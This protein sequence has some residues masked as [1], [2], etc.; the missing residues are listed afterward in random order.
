MFADRTTPHRLDPN[1]PMNRPRTPMHLHNDTLTLSAT[2]L[3]RHLGCE[4]LTWLNR[5]AAEGTL[6]RPTWTDPVLEA[7]IERGKRHEAEY[8]EHLKARGKTVINLDGSRDASRVADLMRQGV[9]VIAQ[10]WLSSHGFNGY[11][12]FLKKVPAPSDLGTWSYE[13][14]DTKLATETKAGTILQLSLYSELVGEIQGRT[15]E[16][17]HVVRPGEDPDPFRVEEYGAYY[18]LVRRWLLDA[19][20]TNGDGL[21]P[22]PCAECAVCD[23]QGSCRARWR[24]D[25]HLTLVAGMT[26][27]HSQEFERQGIMTLAQL[28]STPG[29]LPERPDRGARATYERL[30]NQARVQLEGRKTGRLVHERLSNREK[31]RALPA[32]GPSAADVFF[33][34]E[35]A[36]FH[37]DGGLEYLLGWCTRA[38]DGTPAYHHHWAHDRRSERDAFEGF[39]DAVMEAWDTDPGMHVYHYT[40]Y[41]PSAL[42]RLMGRYGTR[43]TE[44]DRLLRGGR[45]VDLHAVARQGILASVE[46]YSLKDLE[47]FAGYERKVNLRQAGIARRRIEAVLDDPG[48]EM[49]E[50]DRDTVQGY[51]RED[52]EAT[53]ALR[54]WLEQV[55]AEWRQRRD[56]SSAAGAG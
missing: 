41:E 2:D 42:K 43:E 38:P 26:V 53:E 27:Q 44:L 25:D 29:P 3:A 39:M 30:R 28:G 24:A 11:A 36:R 7:L 47:A 31:A 45:L 1:D 22:L 33:D 52:C 12:D 37:E 32:A 35:A 56:R 6:T 13:V 50:G 4:Y 34:I 23:W 17:M 16:Y 46:R 49:P 48:L 5:Q 40:A 9:D 14:T 54:D 19:V 20:A 15:P 10:A 21:Y 8:E 51:N 18:R 55:R